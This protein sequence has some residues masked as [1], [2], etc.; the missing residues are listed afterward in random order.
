[1][2][3]G[4]SNPD[5]IIFKTKKCHFLHPFSDLASKKLCHLDEN[6]DKK[7]FLESI[8]NSHISLSFLLIWN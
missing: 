4:S 1:M 2:P 6:T 7:D 3:L 5:P 8:S